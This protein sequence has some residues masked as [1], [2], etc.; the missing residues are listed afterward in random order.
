M[1]GHTGVCEWVGF[2]FFFC[3]NVAHASFVFCFLSTVSADEM[4]AV[5]CAK[6]SGAEGLQITYTGT[7]GKHTRAHTHGM[8]TP[9]LFLQHKYEYISS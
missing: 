3:S 6:L 9:Y 1:R 7:F 8:C 4:A 5:G 2:F